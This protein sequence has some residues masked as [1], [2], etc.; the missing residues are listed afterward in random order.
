MRPAIVLAAVFLGSVLLLPALIHWLRRRAIL[1]R[2]VAR[3][4]HRL[5]VPR[6][7]GL[8]MTPL[9]ALAWIALAGPGAAPPGSVLVAAAAALLGILS[10]VD[11]L[12][13]LPAAPRLV[14]HLAAAAAAVAVLPPGGTVFQGL[15]PPLLDRAAAALALTWFINLYNFMDGID[16]IAGVE[17][18]C[19]GLGIAFVVGIGGTDGP[20]AMPALALAAAALGF[21]AWNWHPAKIFLGDVGS[22]PIGLLAGWLLLQ[23]ACAGLWAPAL[24]LPLYYLADASA[25]MARRMLAGERFWQAHRQHAYQRALAPDGDHA[26]VVRIILIGNIGLAGAAVLAA[27]RPLPGLAVGVAATVAVIAALERRAQRRPSPPQ[28][29]GE[30][31]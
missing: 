18:A 28:W 31:G 16:G 21:L 29:G 1:D 24:I 5:P 25:T 27:I 12:R 10:W 22:V 2:P 17:T 13:N 26:A 7:G 30:A 11:D 19:I 4:S 3:S 14:A 9:L 20:A 8:V 23:L 15:L 6:G